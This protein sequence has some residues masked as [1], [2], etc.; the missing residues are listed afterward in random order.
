MIHAAPDRMAY[1]TEFLR[2]RLEAQ[3]FK[4]VIVWEDYNRVGCREAYLASFSTLPDSGHTW[5]LQDDVLPDQRF[6]EWATG[7]WFAKARETDINI[8]EKLPSGKFC[9]YFFKLYIGNNERVIGIYNFYPNIVEHVDEYITGSL[10]NTQRKRPANG[11]FIQGFE[12]Q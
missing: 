6:Y 8:L 5:H 4:D 9:D 12:M 7:E 1:V 2:P 10:V 11:L 3:G